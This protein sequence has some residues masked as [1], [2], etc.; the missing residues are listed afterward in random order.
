MLR[1]TTS[2][3]L[4]PADISFLSRLFSAFSSQMSEIFSTMQED[5]SIPEII[6]SIIVRS[7]IIRQKTMFSYAE[8]WINWFRRNRMF[9]TTVFFV[10][11]VTWTGLEFLHQLPSR[12]TL[13]SSNSFGLR[14]TVVLPTPWCRLSDTAF[15]SLFSP[16]SADVVCKYKISHLLLL[17]NC[18][19]NRDSQSYLFWRFYCIFFILIRCFWY[20]H[21]AILVV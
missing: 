16:L 14:H 10:S 9:S 5:V 11:S 17:F 3:F 6:V 18:K 4:N 7:C 12:N 1:S 21:I 8:Q 20:W 19:N 2:G 15:A 13:F